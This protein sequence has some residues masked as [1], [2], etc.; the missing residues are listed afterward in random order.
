[1]NEITKAGILV[2]VCEQCRGMWLDRGELEKVAARLQDLEDD[3]DRGEEASRASLKE[4]WN[5]M[6]S[7]FVE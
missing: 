4:R 5:R 6:I 7:I 2:D 1:L 3:L